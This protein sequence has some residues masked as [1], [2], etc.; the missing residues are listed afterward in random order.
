MQRYAIEQ[1]ADYN[2]IYLSPHLDDAALSC[3]GAIIGQRQ[4]GERVLVVTICTAA[5]AAEGPF[6]TLAEEFHR[7]WGLQPDQVVAARL[8]EDKAAME[9]LG[10]DFL[11]AGFLDAIY[12]NPTAYTTRESLF[13]TP[14][15]DDPLLPELT[16]FI[17]RL[18]QTSPNA[19]VYAPLSV[20]FHVDHQ[21][22]QAA[23][24]A[25]GS[26]HFYEDVPYAVQDGAVEARLDRL[27]YSVTP[28][29]VPIGDTLSAKIAAIAAY[30]S[31]LAELFRADP[32]E[33]VI[34]D[35]HATIGSE[36]SERVWEQAR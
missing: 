32:M 6:N 17:A 8:R 29:L 35:Y 26:A 36:P 20:G 22:T 7:Y 25:G 11:W 10:V 34:R 28:Q 31:Q 21:I 12:R 23:T 30:A 19:Q 27:G 3:G 4:R 9:Q 14:A 15:P 1:R 33:H 16:Q 2:H 24:L 5:P 18:R 13:G